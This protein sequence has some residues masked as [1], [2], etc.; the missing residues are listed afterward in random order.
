MRRSIDFS[1]TPWQVVTLCLTLAAFGLL[2]AVMPI[3]VTLAGTAIALLALSYVLLQR[4]LRN[5]RVRTSIMVLWPVGIVGLLAWGAW[6]VLR[7]ELDLLSYLFIPPMALVYFQFLSVV[8][9]AFYQRYTDHD[10][11]EPTETLPSVSAI[12]PAYDEEEYIGRA[13]ESLLTTAYPEDKLDIIV[14]DD[15]STDGTF[16][17]AKSY[18]SDRVRVFHKDNGGK[19]SA[20]NYGVMLSDAEVI[21]TID[22]DCIVAP[23][24][25]REVV[26]P[27]VED[28]KIGAVAGDVRVI[29]RQNLITRIQTL[30]YSVG[31]NLLR[32]MFDWFGGVPVVPGCLGAFRRSALEDVSNYD[33]DTLT[34]D[35]DL[36][37]KI[38]KAGYDVRASSALVYTEVPDTWRSLY[39]QRIRWY[40]GNMM[41]QMKH[42]DV[43]FD[44]DYDILHSITFPLRMIAMMVGP[45]TTALV[46]VSIAV[47]ALGD[48]LFS[49]FVIF[50]IFVLI[51]AF[52]TLLA[53]QFKG[54]DLSTIH[55]TLLLS[56][57]YKLFRDA[58]TLKAVVDVLFRSDLDWTSATR[59]RHRDRDDEATR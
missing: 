44:P 35:Y 53:L 12:I 23:N 36:T 20:L 38:L 29:N 25:I 43:F 49:V 1:S 27:F 31:I 56:T 16:Q 54:E 34:E 51:S 10:R 5:E 9:F 3:E 2:Y 15:G 55:Y 50:V 47:A 41:T 18:A 52:S 22:A 24:A 37:I 59:I 32:R 13:I 28:P 42:S 8:P 58:I 30:E 14:V 46:I 6:R 7:G 11:F 57:V 21:V 45:L 48:A 26:P 33:P 4:R 39:R 19:H 17:K 40:R